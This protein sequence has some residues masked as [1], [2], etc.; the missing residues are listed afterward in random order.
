MDPLLKDWLTIGFSSIA[1]IF[2]FASLILAWRNFRRD[3][4]RLKINIRYKV[5]PWQGGIYTVRITNIGRR[6]ASLT[7]VYARYK[8]GKRYPVMDIPTQLEETQFKDLSVEMAGFH[9]DHPLSIRA[10]EVEDSTGKVY[11]AHTWK[12]W[13]QLRKIRKPVMD[14]EKKVNHALLKRNHL[15]PNWLLL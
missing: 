6:P 5:H 14:S 9:N 1:L 3:A 13:W 10:F 2:S 7:H 8:N 11:K 12:L 15:L 4:S